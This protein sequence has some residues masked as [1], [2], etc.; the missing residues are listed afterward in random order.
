VAWLARKLA[1]FGEQLTAGSIVLSGSLGRAP[2][3]A[4]GDEITLRITDN[5]P[6]TVR[7]T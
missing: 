2:D 1:T 4:Q 5:P 3:V 6:L 7:F